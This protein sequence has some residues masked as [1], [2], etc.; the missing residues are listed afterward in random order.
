MTAEKSWI[1]LNYSPGR[2]G[3]GRSPW[4]FANADGGPLNKDN[5]N[6]RSLKPLLARAG[7]P[8]NV[9]FQILC[10][11]HGTLLASKGVSPRAVQERLGRSNVRTTLQFYTEVVPSM[12]DAAVEA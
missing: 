11:T 1:S 2:E 4:V 5:V 9:T 12:R 7:L 8:N 10:R 3:L 6:H